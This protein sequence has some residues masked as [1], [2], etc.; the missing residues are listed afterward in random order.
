MIDFKDRDAQGPSLLIVLSL[1]ILA[2][3]LAY[4]L[5]VPMPKAPNSFVQQKMQT[6]LRNATAD[7]KARRMG[8]RAFRTPGA[9]ARRAP[10]AIDGGRGR[11]R[12]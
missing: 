12:K 7:A 6:T 10:A 3:T 2:G 9:S 5:L 8:S 4:S 1:L 11:C